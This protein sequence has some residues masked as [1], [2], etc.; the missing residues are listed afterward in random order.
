MRSWG[1]PSASLTAV[2]L[3]EL[4]WIAY[5]GDEVN[6]SSLLHK[7]FPSSSIVI[8][9]SS[10]YAFPRTVHVYFPPKAGLSG[11]THVFSIKGTST[12]ADVFADTSMYATVQIMQW[13][14]HIVPTISV[15][16]LELTQWIIE[17]ASLASASSSF[18]QLEDEIRNVTQNVSESVV[19]TGHSLGGGIA[20][21]MAN[22]LAVPAVVF[23]A[24][25][26]IFSAAHFNV[27]LET[28]EHE[29]VVVEPDEDLV[30]RVDEQ[31]GPVQRI[32][33]RKLDGTEGH[34]QDCHSLKRTT[35]ELW[36]VC[37]DA[38]DRDFRAACAQFVS[39][40][41]MGGRFFQNPEYPWRSPDGGIMFR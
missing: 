29:T 16:P 21:I 33:C 40:S 10:Y 9:N 26:I 18:R 27:S 35:C 38:A 41:Y 36:R 8:N 25:G 15:L 37:G 14:N 6:L 19:I 5:A 22:R 23:S 17:H 12:S 30:P 24:P 34:P 31:A 39:P 20:Q 7:S 28:A 3:A 32:A 11:G 2:D 13:L 4:S 1:S